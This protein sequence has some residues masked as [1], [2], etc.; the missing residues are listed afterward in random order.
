[1]FDRLK[2]LP[3]FSAREL[4]LDMSLE[5]KAIEGCAEEEY[6]DWIALHARREQRWFDVAELLIR[7]EQ[8]DLI[9]IVFDG[10][11]KLQHLCWRFIDPDCRPETPSPWQ[12]QIADACDEYFR[13]LDAMIGQ[14]VRMAGPDATVVF[15]S[16]HGAGP[17]SDIFC[18]NAWLEQEGYLA[19]AAEGAAKTD[20]VPEI[21]FRQ[22]ARHVFEL[23]WSK[24]VAYAAT[25][26]SQGIHIVAKKPGSSESMDPADYLRL[27]SELAER[28]L[29]V[30]SPIT[31]GPV[32]EAVHT[33]EA[34]F[35]GPYASLGPD[36]TLDLA[37]G[38]VLSIA[39]TDSPFKRRS[40]PAGSHRPNGIFAASGPGIRC[41]ATLTDLSIVDV[42][43]FVLHSLGLPVPADVAGQVPVE[44]FDPEA[45]RLRPPRTSAPRSSNGPAGPARAVAV[46]NDEEEST[47]LRRLQAL[48]YVE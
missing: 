2:A 13:Q 22:L 44:A 1:L 20:E 9:G 33:R 17:T 11:D 4:A 24:T 29:A 39:R 18:L 37:D 45:L 48:G 36:L 47:M 35:A 46:L 41:G 8:A 34:V 16:D 19:W 21:G 12:Q 27:Q 43:P 42:A 31:G 23:D 32:V 3:S 5:E 14:L 6:A 28:L 30:R 26:S 38:G 25:P 10:V 15:A 40:E 7:E